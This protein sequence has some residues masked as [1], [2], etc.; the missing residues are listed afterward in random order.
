MSVCACV[1]S[2]KYMYVC[3]FNYKYSHKPFYFQ[4]NQYWDNEKDRSNSYTLTSS[5]SAVSADCIFFST[6]CRIS[7]LKF[8]ESAIATSHMLYWLNSF[9]LNYMFR[10]GLYHRNLNLL[11]DN[12]TAALF[13]K[14]VFGSLCRFMGLIFKRY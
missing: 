11:P 7:L 6:F 12:P 9:P 13:L 2:Y 3:G 1:R 8:S 10:K 4:I 14:L 5:G